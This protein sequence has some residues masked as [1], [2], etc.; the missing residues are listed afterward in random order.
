MDLGL[1][2]VHDDPVLQIPVQAV[3]LLDEHHRRVPAALADVGEHLPEVGAPG[4]LGGLD[5]DEL[6]DDGEAVGGGVLVDAL[7]LRGDRE[8]LALLVTRRDARVEH[9]GAAGRRQRLG[10][11]GLLGG[12]VAGVVVHGVLASGEA[13]MDRAG[14]S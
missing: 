11:D 3:R 2:L 10:D 4:L 8:A 1:H 13:G 9:G 12:A 6:L 7:L 5:V 14:S